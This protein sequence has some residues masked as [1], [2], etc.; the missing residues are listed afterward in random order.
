M[1]YRTFECKACGYEYDERE[2]VC[3]EPMELGKVDGV[4]LFACPDCNAVYA[5]LSQALHTYEDDEK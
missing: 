1:L 4:S 5:D 3:G 2:D